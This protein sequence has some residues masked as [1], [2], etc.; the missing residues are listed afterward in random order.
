M[1]EPPLPD[2]LVPW[3]VLRYQKY[4]QTPELNVSSFLSS[5]RFNVIQ[6]GPSV[7]FFVFAVFVGSSSAGLNGYFEISLNLMA[8]SLGSA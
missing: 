4:V 1:V 7:H 8:G 6:F 3:R 2:R 5:I